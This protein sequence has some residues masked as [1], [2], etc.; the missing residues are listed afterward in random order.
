[1]CVAQAGVD[2]REAGDDRIEGLLLFAE[3]LGALGVVPD[4]GILELSCNDL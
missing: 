1:V 2:R 3:L 4:L